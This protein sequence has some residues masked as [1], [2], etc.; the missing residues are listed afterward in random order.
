[1]HI[2]MLNNLQKMEETSTP[3]RLS[4]TT[5][6]SIDVS[7]PDEVK[8]KAAA[9]GTPSPP[10]LEV[11]EQA[12]SDDQKTN[13]LTPSGKI[14]RLISNQ[15]AVIAPATNKDQTINLLIRSSII[16]LEAAIEADITNEEYD[17]LEEDGKWW[18]DS[19][20]PDSIEE[21]HVE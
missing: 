3:N 7:D 12:T 19:R 14:Q 21:T 15:S 16:R 11:E 17:D 13:L 9:V 20:F 5:R 10:Q 1:M 6:T 18:N 2:C 4:A 8:S